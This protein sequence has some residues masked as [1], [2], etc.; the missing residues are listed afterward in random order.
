MIV[1]LLLI[2]NTPLVSVIAVVF[3]GKEKLI[4]SPG[5]T[6]TMACRSVQSAPGQVP[7][8]SA[9]LLTVRVAADVEATSARKTIKPRRSVRVFIS[10]LCFRGRREKLKVES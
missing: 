3:T 10:R 1:R 4:V 2:N 7:P 5:A 6:V 8:A 9:V